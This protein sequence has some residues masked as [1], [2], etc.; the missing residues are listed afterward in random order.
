[1]QTTQESQ[2]E[3]VSVLIGK[4]KLKPTINWAGITP[5]GGW[6]PKIHQKPRKPIGKTK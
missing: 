2:Q 4:P 3:A 1:M 6:N 5:M